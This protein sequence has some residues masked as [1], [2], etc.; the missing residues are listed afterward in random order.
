[1]LSCFSYFCKG[2]LNNY[3][4]FIKKRGKLIIIIHN[5]SVNKSLFK[6]F[7][8]LLVERQGFEPWVPLTV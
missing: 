8:N 1:M 5:K 6:C 4:I 2:K 7:F 3:N